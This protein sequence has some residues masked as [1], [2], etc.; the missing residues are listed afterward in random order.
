MAVFNKDTLGTTYR[1]DFDEDKGFY[2]ILFNSGVALQ[3]RELTQLQTILGDQIEKFAKNI[4]VDGS[5]VEPG[6]VSIISNYEYIKVTQSTV[7]NVTA[8]D[9]LRNAGNTIRAE[10]IN[11]I[12]ATDTDPSVIYVKY[13]NTSGATTSLTTVAN[14]DIRFKADDVLTN[15]ANSATFNVEA[16]G[17]DPIGFGT[18]ADVQPGVYFTRGK[19]V[20]F[21]GGKIVISKFSPTPTETLGFKVVQ[22][23]VQPTDDVSLYDNANPGAVPNQSSPG[24]DRYRIRLELA[25]ERNIDSDEQFIF[26]TDIVGGIKQNQPE[27]TVYGILGDTLAERTKEESGDYTVKD[28]DLDIQTGDTNNLVASLTPGIAYVNGFRIEKSDKTNLLLSK[29][30][31]T[32]TINNEAVAANIGNFITINGDSGQF[33]G[34]PD[35]NSFEE[36]TLKDS[37]GFTGNTLGTARVR[38]VVRSGS[39][40]RFHLFDIQMDSANNFRDTRSLGSS[41]NS[42]GN[43]VLENNIAVLKETS[44]NNLFFDLSREKAKSVTDVSFDVQR[45]FEFSTGVGE[46][47]HTETLTT[48]GETFTNINDWIFID[49]TNNDRVIDTPTFTGGAGQASITFSGLTGSNSYEIIGYVNKSNPTLKIK[50]LRTVTETL[51]GTGGTVNLTNFDIFSLDSVGDA[52]ASNKNIKSRYTL[53]NGQRDNFFTTGRLLLKSG[54]STPSG[55]VQVKYRYFEHENA[56]D[57]FS[58]N[59]YKAA[60]V[61][62]GVAPE[63]IPTYRQR[64]GEVIDFRNYLDFRS[65][66][67]SALGVF[68]E[69]GA[70]SIVELPKSTDIITA[71]I[72]YYQGRKDAIVVEGKSPLTPGT[73]RA[74]KIKVIQGKSDFDPEIPAIPDTAMKIFDLEF[75]PYTDDENDII[76]DKIDNRRYTMRDIGDIEKRIDNLEEVTSLTLLELETSSL[77][78]LDANGNNRFKNGFFADN[79]KSLNFSDITDEQYSAS[80]DLEAGI[81]GPKYNDKTVELFHD[82]DDGDNSNIFFGGDRIMLDFDESPFV[83]QTLA[84]ETE[85]LNPYEFR[86]VVGDLQIT[87]QYDYFS[88]TRIIGTNVVGST[89]RTI[90]RNGRPSRTVTT[91][92]QVVGVRTVG[93]N[94][95]PFMRHRQVWFR[96]TGLRPN[97]KYFSFLDDVNISDFTIKIDNLFTNLYDSA[98]QGT[99][100]VVVPNT[101][102][103]VRTPAVVNRALPTVSEIRTTVG[104]R[105]S[106]RNRRTRRRNAVRVR[107]NL[108]GF[109][110]PTSMQSNPLNNLVFNGISVADPL[111]SGAYDTVTQHPLKD[112]TNAQALITDNFGIIEGSFFVPNNPNLNIA[113]TGIRTAGNSIGSLTLSPETSTTSETG[114]AL[115]NFNNND[116]SRI[117]LS[118]TNKLLRF[119]SG[120]IPF[121]LIDISELDLTGA[122][123]YAQTFYTSE[124]Q[125]ILQVRDIVRR[126]TIVSQRRDHDP[127][128]QSFFQN[129]DDGAFLSRIDVYFANKNTTDGGDDVDEDVFLEVRPVENGVPSQENAVPGSRVVLSNKDINLP[130]VAEANRTIDDLVPTSF[131]FKAPIH[132]DGNREYAFILI[133]P[134]NQYNVYVA[135]TG[136]LLLGRTDRRVTRQ[137]LLG[138]LFMS[139]NSITWTPDQTRDIMFRLWRAK[140]KRTGNAKLAN[141]PLED[142][143]LT[144]DPFS[145]TNA[146]SNVSVFHPNHGFT[147]NDEI[148]LYV[149]DSDELTTV[150]NFGGVTGT[151][152]L[153]RKTVTK[154]D[155][156]FFQFAH[157]SAPTSTAVGGGSKIMCTQNALVDEIIPMIQDFKPEPTTLT[158]NANLTQGVGLALANDENQSISYGTPKGFEVVPFQ[159]YLLD[160]PRVIAGETIEEEENTLLDQDSGSAR[161]SLEIDVSLTT[162]TDWVSPVIYSDVMSMVARAN[163]IDNQDSDA[164]AV[165]P[166]NNP[167]TFV[168]EATAAGGSHLSKHITRPIVL[169]EAAVG[170]K[171]LL[172]ANRPAYILNDEVG[173]ADFDVYYKTVPIGSDLTLDDVS[174]ILASKDFDIAA[175]ANRDVFRQYEYT[176]GG[177][178][179]TLSPFTTFAIKVVMRSANT[180]APPRFR[181][182]RVIALGT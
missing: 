58:I 103:Q 160:T 27:R 119:R 102:A 179:G 144:A 125:E 3:G 141:M 100:L 140:F 88:E 120:T 76:I 139:Q 11:K 66:K 41:V 105:N 177:L 59:S 82:V 80:I 46:T 56:G 134:N 14:T 1:D 150:A 75:K 62:G 153:G 90:R 28:F 77:E 146:D 35:I 42:Y 118:G 30:R 155:G 6:G 36:L 95:L 131:K 37:T 10:V 94:I 29:A 7:D 31:D 26:L 169:D 5:V 38:Q 107:P 126:T 25:L 145:V 69:T 167:V 122:A 127:L 129:N 65:F 78:V 178:G 92:F 143:Q 109:T 12:N 32:E 181:D 147:K 54:Q 154:V 70:N 182:L 50:D 149:S 93:V 34:M 132:L 19:F 101:G 4:F 152:L 170:L 113:R 73:S 45:K 123:S 124:G 64:N 71:D 166:L 63:D 168:N 53:D 151:R 67:D 51:D 86:Q 173:E 121:T 148:D 74:P 57:Y 159:N 98:S 39:N 180:S 21:P 2:Q 61:S 97:T 22:D 130:T 158:Y 115:G 89:T 60:S 110:T 104:N 114:D 163:I 142:V 83:L 49:K 174:W 156:D 117:D 133:A 162:T 72:E 84:T 175:D 81:L 15:L 52:S 20:K 96:A 16:G 23:V 171:V 87:P 9:I 164:D 137:P 116:D 157:D 108:S 106:R 172:G 165:Y 68:T 13:V 138:S 40:Y 99:N 43:I 17:N 79:F 24:A 161:L 47:E 91:T 8:G 111:T 18:Y 135:R 112:G 44:N 128:A 33:A 136:D 48:S 55:N 176:I 85:N